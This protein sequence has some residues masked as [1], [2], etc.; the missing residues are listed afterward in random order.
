MTDKKVLIEKLIKD[1][2]I[3]L[4]EALILLG[5]DEMADTILPILTL[6][7]YPY[8]PNP[9]FGIYP[10]SVIVSGYYPSTGTIVMTDLNNGTL[11]SDNY[12]TCVVSSIA[13]DPQ[14]V[15]YTMN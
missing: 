2:A 11:T 14:C 12:D 15:T 6:P 13:I 3:T 9:W 8:Y 4:D 5:N 7:T 1:S 10:P